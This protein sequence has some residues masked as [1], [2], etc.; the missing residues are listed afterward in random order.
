M[1]IMFENEKMGCVNLSDFF[2]NLEFAIGEER[3]GNSVIAAI[4]IDF[5]SGISGTNADDLQLSVQ[6][7][8]LI[9]KRVQLVDPWR[10]ALADG[11]IHAEYLHDDDLGGQITH[12]EGVA[13]LDAKIVPL[14]GI[15]RQ[16]QGDSRPQGI[17]FQLRCITPCG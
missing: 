3:K 16:G 14:D 4:K 5:I 7:A 11:T 17:G 9:D 2:M 8:A 10:L 6:V 15:R 1:T 12:R 13:L